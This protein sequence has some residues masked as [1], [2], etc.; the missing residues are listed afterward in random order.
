MSAVLS[1][2]RPILATLLGVVLV[3]FERAIV[4]RTHGLS[5]TRTAFDLR[6]RARPIASF[7]CHPP[8]AWAAP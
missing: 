1:A 4:R 7:D 2:L 8:E 3:L 6:R 5:H